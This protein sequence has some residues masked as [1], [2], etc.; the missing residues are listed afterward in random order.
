MTKEDTLFDIISKRHEREIERSKNLDEKSDRLI[1]SVSIIIAITITLGSISLA[2]ILQYTQ[3]YVP[4]FMGVGALLTAVFLS[5]LGIRLRKWSEIPDDVLVEKYLASTN[6]D[7]FKEEAIMSISNVYFANF[8][9][10]EKKAKYVSYSWICMLI[11]LVSLAVFL[12]ILTQ[13]HIP[14]PTT[15]PPV[16]VSPKHS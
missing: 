12:A 10:N 13:T 15:T 3:L 11:G 4:F 1:Q 9:K 14:T 7:T 2:N 6:D 16:L 5:L 8:D